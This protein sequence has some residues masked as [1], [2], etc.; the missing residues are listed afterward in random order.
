[1]KV[2]IVD[3]GSGNIRSIKNWVQKS[4]IE[5]RSVNQVSELKSDIL[6][7]PGVGTVGSYMARL[8]A[9]SF[10][11]A[12]IEHVQRGG[13]L[14]GICLGFQIMAH[15]SEEDGGVECLNLIDAQVYRLTDQ[16]SHN[17]WEFLSFKKNSM[18]GQSFNS[19]Q[20]LTRKT[21]LTGRVFYNHEYGVIN[22][23]KEAFTVPVSPSLQQYTG[24]FVKNRIVGIQ[25]HPEKSQITG[26]ELISMIL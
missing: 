6:I 23:D 13:R 7:L 4:N 3:V 9:S 1:M 12:V 26:I 18:N 24:L 5:A 25:F 20:K 22:M 11:K 8:K 21:V 2:D 15:F 19:S 10:D 16:N 14:I 17:G